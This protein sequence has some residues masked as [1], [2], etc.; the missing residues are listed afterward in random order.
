MSSTVV[1]DNLL[2]A[3]YF[4]VLILIPTM[5]YFRSKYRTPYMDELEK[6]VGDVDNTASSYWGR[7]DISL[8]DIALAVGTTFIIVAVSFKLAEIFD[9]L[10]PSDENVSFFFNLLNGIFG[11]DYLMLTTITLLSVTLFPRYFES[12]NGAQE[13]GSYM[14][15]IFFVVIGVPASLSLILQHAPFILIFVARMVLI[16]MIVS[17]GAGGGGIVGALVGLGLPEEQAKQFEGFLKQGK[18]IV[19]VEADQEQENSVY[20]TFLTHDTENTGMYPERTVAKNKR[21]NK[22]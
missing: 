13:I 17:V 5:N 14:I 7:K 9:G 16:N 1:A 10:I 2:M 22:W 6:N 3:L 20:E 12:I 21:T 15:Y 4:L 19:L 11:D 18:I 8:K